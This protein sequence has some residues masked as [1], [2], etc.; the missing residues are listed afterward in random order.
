[1][2]N[3]GILHDDQKTVQKT[4]AHQNWVSCALEW[5]G[6]RQPLMKPGAYTQLFFLDDATALSAGHRPCAL[7][8][9]DRYTEF[10]K[11]WV[12]MYGAPEDG[13]SLPQTIDRTLHAARIS[14]RQKVTFEADLDDLPDG[15]FVSKGTDAYLKWSG[16]CFRWGFDGYAEAQKNLSGVVSVLTPQPLIPVLQAGYRPSVHE[17]LKRLT[18]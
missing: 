12:E 15:T 18:A 4:H 13:Q 9:R 5:K 1:M 11:L 2:G 6:K 10:T 7:C 14:R 8:R 3:R 16:T 17:S